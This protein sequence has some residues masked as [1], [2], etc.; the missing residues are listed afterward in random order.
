MSNRRLE[1]HNI[2][3]GILGTTG[4][5]ESRVYFQ[6]PATVKLKYPC[7]IYSRSVVDAKRA[8]NL[9]YQSR[10]GYQVMVIDQNPDSEYP[11][12]VIHL[13]LSQFDRHYTSDGLNHDVFTVYY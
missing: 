5:K 10:V 13:P 4:Q 12:K 3:M 9:L 1:L 6:P 8:D 11:S 2:L 7:I